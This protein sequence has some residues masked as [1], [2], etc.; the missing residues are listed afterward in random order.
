QLNSVGVNS[1]GIGLEW[2]P[3]S[4]VRARGSYQ[5]TVRAAN[6]IELFAPQAVALFAAARDDCAGPT[7]VRSLAQ[8]ARTGVTAAQY[9]KIPE[10]SAGQYNQLV[11][12]NTALKPETGKSTTFGVVLTPWKDFSATIDYFRIDLRDTISTVPPATTL[13]QCYDT[14]NPTFCNLV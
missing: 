2:Q 12:G 14:G 6:I 11:G 4:T 5:Q 10:N 7:P 8:C 3:V 1:Y 9:G 13:A